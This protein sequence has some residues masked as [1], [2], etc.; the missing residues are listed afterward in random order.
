MSHYN[1]CG[2]GGHKHNSC[3]SCTSHNE[4]QQAV[5]D[6]LAFEKENLE[7]YEN[8]AAQSAS[9]AAKEAAKAAESASA[10]A[11]SQANAE[12]A[13]GTAVAASKVVTDTAVVLEETANTIKAA[14]DLL[15]E[16]VAAVQTK[17]VYFEVTTETSSLV[18]PTTD[19][20]FN[21]RSIY[22][23]SARQA[24]NY[25]FTF[26]KNTRTV[27]LAEP[28]T[29]DQIAETDE[30]YILVE[31][32][33][34]VFN[35]DD[36]TSLGVSLA[37]NIGTTLIGTPTGETLEETLVRMATEA[38][39]TLRADL[40]SGA[41]GNG[42]E[43][44][45]HTQTGVTTQTL[46]SF[47]NSSLKFVTPLMFSSL[48]IDGNWTP[49]LAA[50]DLAAQTLGL[51]LDGQGQTYTLGASV[52]LRCAK[53]RNITLRPLSTYV[54][55]APIFTPDA[56]GVIEH[57]SVDIS[58][59]VL[60]GCKFLQSTY[61]GDTMAVFKGF[62]RYNNNGNLVRTT[63]T[64]DVNTATEF[65]V[66]V[67]DASIFSAEDPIHIGDGRYKILSISGNNI[68]LYNDGTGATLFDSGTRY[69]HYAGQFVT[70]N[71]GY[72]NNGIRIGNATQGWTIHVLGEV[73]CMNNGWTGFYHNSGAYNGYHSL[74]KIRANGNGYIGIGLG[75]VNK[76]S[77]SNCIAE[78]NGN[79]GI[80]IFEAKQTYLVHDNIAT[81]NGV[82]NIFVGGLGEVAAVHNNTCINAFRIGILIFGRTTAIF[83]AELLNN[84]CQGNKYRSIGFT[85]VRYGKIIGGNVGGAN[86]WSIYVEGRTGLN[87]P[88]KITIKNVD[89]YQS[90]I[91]DVGGN[92]RNNT[93]YAAGTIDL[94][95]NNTFSRM[96]VT[97]ISNVN[98]YGCKFFPECYIAGTG[99]F[100]AA[101]GATISVALSIRRPHNSTVT[102]AA[103]VQPV[104]FTISA[105]SDGSDQSTVTS[106]NK[107]LTNVTELLNT[108]A[109]RGKIIAIPDSGA[110]SYNFVLSAPGTRYILVESGGFRKLLTLVWS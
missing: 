13:A 63:L 98:Y 106:A 44:L 64:A 89:M 95:D 85:G 54:G 28:I 97:T 79:N 62:C 55:A 18:L 91:G 82:D 74:S 61:V 78:N 100:T 69:Q 43:L 47:L 93:S 38:D 80:D 7:Q 16:Q 40:I 108:A 34:D 96:P 53:F 15:D 92:L 99:D 39:P 33:C 32:I 66:A 49:A 90:T 58:N 65:V 76:G 67:T 35:S 71:Q 109:T 23:A 3:N 88:D 31:V 6:A 1:G 50:A 104:T 17:P 42:T 11:Q 41:S 24:L 72:D 86:N 9:D 29:A 48:V 87:N 37:S 10:A 19:T 45:S 36:P 60:T 51:T 26:D 46:A 4:I 77:I 56:N 105:N 30:G 70:L 57:D 25:G 12:T 52:T 107:T 14:Q 110:V 84:K 68:T 21:V 81:G 94:I 5:N 75:Y 59:F 27:T 103:A 102:D 73:E 20:V 83:G 22:I 2:C 8:N 101:A